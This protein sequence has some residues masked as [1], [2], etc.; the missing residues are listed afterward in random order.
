MEVSSIFCGISYENLSLAHNDQINIEILAQ[1]RE[2]EYKL[3]KLGIVHGHAHN[4]NF[5]VELINKDFIESE[6]ISGRNINQLNRNARQNFSYDLSDYRADPNKW[7]IVVRLIDWDQA[8]F[9]NV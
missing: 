6:A 7:E 9:K 2:I 4:G 8:S 1:A 3:S 5:V